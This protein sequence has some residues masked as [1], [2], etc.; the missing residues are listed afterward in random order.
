MCVR[1]CEENLRCVQ[2]KGVSLLDLTTDLRL[3]SRQS[4]TQ[5]EACK[6]LRVT[7]A[8]ALQ[9]KIYK[10]TRLYVIEEK[11]EELG[12]KSFRDPSS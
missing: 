1:K 7:T 11:T 3:A 8:R 5:G 6:E 2:I 12:K 10:I 9:D 4:S